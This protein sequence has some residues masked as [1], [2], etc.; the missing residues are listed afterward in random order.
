MVAPLRR[1]LVKRPGAAFGRA[2]QDPALGFMHAVDLPRA[3]GEHDAFVDL[4][5]RLGV[6]VD[7]LGAES[8]SADD[9]YT[10]DPLLVADRGAIALRSGRASRRVETPVLAGWM[11]GHGIPTLGTIE[12]PG[13]VDGG[14][15]FWLRPDLLCIGR[16][17]RTNG[18]G[19]R[20]LAALAT[21]AGGEGR[22]FD[23]PYWRGPGELLHLLSVISPVADDLAVVY[24]PLLPIGLWELLRDLGIRLLPVP[25][26][27]FATLGCNILAIRPGV[28]VVASGNPRTRRALEAAGC[29]VHAFEAAEIGLNG[30]GGPTCLTRPILRA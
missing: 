12:A 21:A 2:F 6:E 29:E 5:V 7:G 22:V 8:G 1:A 4:L 28:V 9:I 24:E 25:D 3:Q 14:D 20:Q 17:L 15:T 26:E 18:A 13:T 16:G 23:L 19:A 10:F 30:G 11:T 27:E